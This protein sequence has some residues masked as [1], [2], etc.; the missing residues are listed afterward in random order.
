VEDIVS[1]VKDII[2][3]FAK[4]KGKT[5]KGEGSPEEKEAVKLA[6]KVIETPTTDKEEKSS[7]T[8]KILGGKNTL[9][10]VGG[11]AAAGILFTVLKK[12]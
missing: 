8:N 5:D 4:A 9:F 1:I 11:L 6:T 10:I 2:G 12:K 3:F 7:T